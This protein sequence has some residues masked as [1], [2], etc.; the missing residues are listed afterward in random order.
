MPG[1]VCVNGRFLPASRAQ[2]SAADQG[3]LY[4]YGL[5][6][7]ILIRAGQPVFLEAHLKRLEAGCAALGITLPFPLATVGRLVHE[8]IGQNGLPEGALRLTIS[9]GADPGRGPGNLVIFTRPLPYGP[10]D[11]ERGLAAGWSA[12][13]R[14][15]RSPLVKLK[16]LNYLENLLAKREAREK[17]WDEALFLNTAGCVAEGAVSNVFI[18]RNGRA[19]TPSDDQGLLPGIMRRIVLKTC[20]ELGIPVVERPVAP[21]ELVRADECFLTNSLL[22]VMPLVKINDRP[23]GN[24]KPGPVAERI[25]N[26]IISTS[27]VPW[28]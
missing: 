24:G 13:R 27:I 9:A 5:F 7:T 14:N 8:T 12:Y 18:V 21:A 2:I 15:E 22:V 1:A 4:G 6:E 17:G 10:P 11:F 25:R 16:T 20:C 3:F 23:I 28:R 26:S 19:V